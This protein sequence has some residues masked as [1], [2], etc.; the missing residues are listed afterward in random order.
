MI[1][2]NIANLIKYIHYLVILYVFTGHYLTPIKYLHYYLFLIIF[3]FLDWNDYDGQCILTK[4]E[5]YFRTGTMN[6]LSVVEGGPQFFRPIVNKLF[7]L[8]L[9]PIEA[10]RLYNFLFM[11]C[12]L[13]GFIRLLLHYRIGFN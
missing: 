11:I 4:L 3:I 8:K 12:F 9:T 2:H 13:I 10:D 6:Q 1:N 7:N 5:H